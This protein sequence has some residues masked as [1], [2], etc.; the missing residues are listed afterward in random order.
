MKKILMGLFMCFTILTTVGMV[1]VVNEDLK[2]ESK[3][4]KYIFYFIGDGMGMNHVTFLEEYLRWKNDDSELLVS[5]TSM[6]VLTSVATTT[7]G[8]GPLI[9][10]SA[11]AGTMLATGQL[12]YP[13][14]IS[15]NEDASVA[16][17][18]ILQALQ[19]TNRSVGLITD[20]RV[21]HATPAVFGANSPHRDFEIEIAQQYL[22]GGIDFIAGGGSRM[23]LPVEEGGIR[24]EGDNLIDKFLEEGYTV[25]LNM[26]DYNSVDFSTVERYLGVYEPS[27]LTDSITQNNTGRVSPTL[28]NMV[29][30]GIEVL[31]QNEDG[32]FLM[33]EGGYIDMT[34][35]DNDTAATLHEMLEFEEAIQVALE[36]YHQYPEDTLII[37]TADHE[38]GGIGLGY[39]GSSINWEAIEAINGSFK[40]EIEPYFIAGDYNGF[41]NAVETNWNLTLS[42]KDKNDILLRYNNFDLIGLADDL[43]FPVDDIELLLE[44]E[45]MKHMMDIIGF[46]T[47]PVLFSETKVTWSSQAHTASR[48]PLA[49]IG[50]GSE[51]FMG[52]RHLT[53]I[54]LILAELTGVE[55]GQ[56]R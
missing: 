44:M 52:A 21:T 20:V 25:S 49:V 41:F 29:E 34:S 40:Q 50:Q 11:A 45:S 5:M 43:G 42:E 6:P 48:A 2:G 24:P 47:A 31:S 19:E 10:D 39:N 30:S 51:A 36:F 18:T 12:G 9:P 55:I 56:P 8:N 54:P 35:H 38:T 28:A 33:I 15:M 1:N 22:D 7:R 3:E 13:R 46:A 14:V 23:F 4:P 17:T 37:V 32:F 27:H 26:E 53:D 16:Y